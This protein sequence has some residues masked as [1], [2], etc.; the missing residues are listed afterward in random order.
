MV[1]DENTIFQGLIKYLI[2]YEEEDVAKT[3]YI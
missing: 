2:S 1:A 3:L